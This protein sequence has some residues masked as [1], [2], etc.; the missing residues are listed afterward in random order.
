MTRKMK[1][2][3][4]EWIGE[5]PEEWKATKYKYIL[6]ESKNSVRVGPF[7]SQL[8]GD[9]FKEYGYKVFNQ[10]SVL[11]DNFYEVDTFIN[12]K[13][14]EDL[15]AFK[16]NA[17]DILITTRGTIGKIA[18]APKD[19]EEGIIHPCIIKS[20]PNLKKI[21]INF[22]KYI[23]NETDI[24]LE[25]FILD[26]NATTIPVIY[27]EPLKNVYLSL[28]PLKE[29]KKIADYLDNKCAKIDQTVEKE[30]V[31][32]EKLKEYKQS[33]ITEAVTKGL[34]H[35]APMKDSGVEWIGEIPKHW[36]VGVIKYGTLK[37][38]SGKTPKGGSEV[39]KDN[40]II[41]IR[42]QNVYDEGLQL[43][44]CTYISDEIDEDMVGTRVYCNDVLLNITGGS[45]GRC[46]LYDIKTNHAN[47][48][49]HVCIIRTNNDIILPKYMKYFWNS[50]VGKNSIN[51]YQ[52]GANRE[53]LNFEQIGNT[54]IPYLSLEEQK[55]ISDYLDKKCS[56]IDKLISNKEKV[57]EKLTEYKK[58]LIYEC[59]TGKREV[60]NN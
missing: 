33:V 45:I 27:S 10:R 47:V 2:S 42:S 32:I 22:L 25:Q 35:D 7:G 28:P 40:G 20:V 57:I 54:K 13:K 5:I 4:V 3:G 60:S 19:V 46:C 24:T 8:K 41:F 17:G 26:S 48:N 31:V 1:D 51:I 58:S 29:Q 36:K 11:D 15:I 18:V 12:K 16:V 34:N 56:T 14:F 6:E 23:F 53:G 49:Q 30:K 43:E 59:V 38:G 44:N 21:N 52:T 39:Y 9:D 37:I 50:N 55:E